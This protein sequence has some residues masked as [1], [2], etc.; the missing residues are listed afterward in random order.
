MIVSKPHILNASM[1]ISGKHSGVMKQIKFGFINKNI[2]NKFRI[3]TNVDYLY[4]QRNN[5]LRHKYNVI[6]IKTFY[7]RFPRSF[8]W[9]KVKSCLTL[10]FDQKMLSESRWTKK[11][12]YL[13]MILPNQ[14]SSRDD[15]D[16]IL[17]FSNFACCHHFQHWTMLLCLLAKI[18]LLATKWPLTEHWWT[19]KWKIWKASKKINK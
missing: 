5:I 16:K 17:Q 12:N 6:D 18:T 19:T 10:K 2:Q 4:I 8:I 7:S 3:R 15:T 11:G 13:D 9:Y 1:F 14:R